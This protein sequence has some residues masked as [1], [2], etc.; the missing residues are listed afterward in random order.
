MYIRIHSSWEGGHRRW[1]K[2]LQLSPDVQ[3]ISVGNRNAATFADFI[4]FTSA[5]I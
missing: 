2:G 5:G 1:G 4:I 3:H